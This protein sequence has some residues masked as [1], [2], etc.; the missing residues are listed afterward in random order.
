M[1]QINQQPTNG[2]GQPPNP[3]NELLAK[4]RDYALAN[5]ILERK[6]ADGQNPAY[7]S[8]LSVSNLY[9]I[10]VAITVNFY[11]HP[12]FGSFYPS[13][14]IQSGY[15]S[16]SKKTPV[17]LKLLTGRQRTELVEFHHAAFKI[18]SSWNREQIVNLRSVNRTAD[19]FEWRVPFSESD[20]EL[21]ETAFQ[22]L[23]RRKT[24]AKPKENIG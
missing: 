10:V 17:K 8:M 24:D 12:K 21:L 13:W 11:E 20:I 16:K 22:D 6:I 9:F 18:L 7:C 1:N 4:M 15:F 19:S 5:P 2:N 23:I 3:V 14:T